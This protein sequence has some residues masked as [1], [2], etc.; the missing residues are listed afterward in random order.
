MVLIAL[1][2][3]CLMYDSLGNRKFNEEFLV[4]IDMIAMQLT[5][6]PCKKSSLCGIMFNKLEKQMFY[7]IW[8]ER[9]GSAVEC[10]TRD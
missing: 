7:R 2:L 8:R 1:E 4:A 9:S 6:S 10:L 3:A 5:R